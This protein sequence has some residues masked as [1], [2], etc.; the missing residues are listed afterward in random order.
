MEEGVMKKRLII[1]LILVIAVPILTF[2][3]YSEESANLP[4]VR[5]L[6]SISNIYEPVKFD[7]SIHTMYAG[8][9]MT[10]HHEHPNNANQC[11]QCHNIDESLFKKTAVGH[12]IAC[13][14]CHAE[15]DPSNPAMPGLKVAY[16]RKCFQCHRGMGKI[17]IDPKGCTELCH[18]KKG[19]IKKASIK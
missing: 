19:N 2:K 3:V 15:P 14:S 6:S 11:K 16:H 18:A 9:C 17:G 12:F 7:H 1:L 4:T 10:C 8:N 13:S 5:I